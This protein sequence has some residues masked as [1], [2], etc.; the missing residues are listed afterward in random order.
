MMAKRT[1]RISEDQLRAMF[2]M[3]GYADQEFCSSDIASQLKEQ[4]W[5]CGV[6]DSHSGN[7]WSVEFNDGE[8]GDCPMTTLA[9][10]YEEF[11]EERRGRS[12]APVTDRK[13]M[14][15][16]ASSILNDGTHIAGR[17]SAVTAK[18]SNGEE[19]T[20]EVEN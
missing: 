17:L 16:I 3:T 9:G 19:R 13:M 10:I 6:S 2:A 20:Y 12:A 14:E 5:S 11:G 15:S 7:M 8:I 1:L 18:W 4:G